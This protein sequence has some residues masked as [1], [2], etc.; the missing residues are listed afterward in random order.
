LCVYV[1]V[2]PE[3]CATTSKNYALIELL[4]GAV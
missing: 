3:K 1:W 4:N 2:V